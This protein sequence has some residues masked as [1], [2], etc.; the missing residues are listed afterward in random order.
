[1][2][3]DLLLPEMH[4]SRLLGLVGYDLLEVLQSE[5]G[6]C[7]LASRRVLCVAGACGIRQVMQTHQVLVNTFVQLP[8][9]GSALPQ[10]LV[11]IFEAL[12]VGPELLQT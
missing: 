11:V 6:Q 2:G 4:R 5:N 1:M 8:L 12:P 3:K 7:V 9:V 10:L